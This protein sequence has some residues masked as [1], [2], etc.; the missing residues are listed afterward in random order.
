MI[1]LV[2][3]LCFDHELILVIFIVSANTINNINAILI[4]QSQYIIKCQ[5]NTIYQ[6]IMSLAF[7]IK[8]YDQLDQDEDSLT[9]RRIDL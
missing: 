3:W 4:S 8:V 2:Q 1:N 6:R 7:L 5:Y 9:E